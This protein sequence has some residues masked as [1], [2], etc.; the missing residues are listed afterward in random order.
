MKT[1]KRIVVG[2]D[3]SVYSPEILECAAGVAER[4]SS[5]IVAVSI[6]SNRRIE[7]ILTA[8]KDE[9]LARKILRKFIKDETKRRIENLK[10]LISQWVPKQVSTR[11]IIRPGVPYEEILKVV[12]DENADILVINS[13][14]RTKFQDYMFGTT[15]EKI[16][17]HSPVSVLSL[18][19]MM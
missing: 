2:V 19:L 7:D 12:D 18:N 13:R 5:E 1:I 15:A 8:V 10:T 17:K 3:F 14:G 16:F 11:T 4:T 9:H 6:I